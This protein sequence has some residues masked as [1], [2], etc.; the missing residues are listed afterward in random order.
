MSLNLGMFTTYEEAKK[1][2]RVML[3]NNPFAGFVIA[4]FFAGGVAS[5]MSLPFDNAKT[6]LQKQVPD[7]D[8]KLPYKNIFDA[9]KKTVVQDG[10][11]GLWVGLPTFIMRISPHVMITF[12]TAEKLKKIFL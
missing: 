5:V 8:G 1:K 9:M 12:I 2:M 7:A 10:P 11:K 6:K 3:P 4:S